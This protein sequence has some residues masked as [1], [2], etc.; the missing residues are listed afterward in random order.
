MPTLLYRRRVCANAHA[1][2]KSSLTYSYALR[3]L[4][5]AGAPVA[6][7]RLGANVVSF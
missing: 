4:R 5:G 6:G 2:T 7:Y 3:H 1:S